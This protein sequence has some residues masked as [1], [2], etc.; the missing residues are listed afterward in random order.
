MPSRRGRLTTHAI[1]W[2]WR[3]VQRGA[4]KIV[5]RAYERAEAG[6]HGRHQ[7]W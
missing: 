1:A 2:S 3:S 4:M 6:V 5:D 7:H